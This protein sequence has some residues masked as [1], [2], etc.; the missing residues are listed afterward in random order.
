MRELAGVVREAGEDAGE[1]GGS[2]SG[3]TRSDLAREAAELGGEQRGAR[4]GWMGLGGRLRASRARAARGS[5]DQARANE[6][7]PRGGGG[8]GIFHPA[9]G[10]HVRPR[11]DDF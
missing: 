8:G 5:G 9:A 7:L 2:G 11:G 6:R 1:V 10:G 3:P 4:G